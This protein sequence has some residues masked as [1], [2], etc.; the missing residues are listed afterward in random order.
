MLTTQKI[1]YGNDYGTINTKRKL[2]DS[3]INNTSPAGTEPRLRKT[4]TILFSSTVRFNWKFNWSQFDP[5]RSYCVL[6]ENCMVNR[7]WSYLTWYIEGKNIKKTASSTKK[8][9]KSCIFKGSHR[10]NGSSEPNNPWHFLKELN[11][12]FKIHFN[13]SPKL[14]Q[15]FFCHHQKIQ[16][17]EPFPWLQ[18]W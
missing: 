14:W 2:L 5:E 9:T 13:I 11:K 18:L 4:L 3:K 6:S 10:V 12:I 7:L 17:H 1:H 8:M 16:K 15:F